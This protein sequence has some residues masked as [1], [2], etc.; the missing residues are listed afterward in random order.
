M[1]NYGSPF[2]LSANTMQINYAELMKILNENLN[3]YKND[4]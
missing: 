2:N 1:D 4:A 3:K